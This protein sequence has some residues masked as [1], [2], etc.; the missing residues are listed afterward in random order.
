MIHDLGIAITVPTSYKAKSSVRVV[1]IITLAPTSLR[2]AWKSINLQRISIK[3][4]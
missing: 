1:E 4:A 3:M 2:T